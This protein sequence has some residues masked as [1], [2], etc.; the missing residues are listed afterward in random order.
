[1]LL[2][3]LLLAALMAPM[4]PAAD[5]KASSAEA[6]ALAYLAR[7]VP[8]W[9]RENHCF[10]CHNNGDAARALYAGQRAG[11]TIPPSAL[12]DTTAWLTHPHRWD[13]NGGRGPFSDKRLARVQF[14]TALAA[15]LEAGSAADP[16]A[17]V[18][19]AA[20]LVPDQAPDGSWPIEGDESGGPGSPATYGR[21]LATHLAR[22]YLRAADPILFREPIARA[23]RWL[24]EREIRTVTDASVALLALDSD[25]SKKPFT[26]QDS[27]LALL[28]KDQSEDG[29]WGPFA[30]SPPEVFDTALAVL[31]LSR[32]KL[33][34]DDRPLIARGRAFL[35]ERQRP[36]GSWIETTRPPGAESYA[37]RISTTGW[38]ALA[39]LATTDL[40]ITRGADPKR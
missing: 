12:A 14:T 17:L 39:L 7:E 2:E 26:A 20:L 19:A 23:G 5:P 25:P 6:L 28:R 32:I 4:L 3:P 8:R 34:P 31:G 29:G 35:I 21:P 10:S 16:G 33:D 1:M 22:E 24:A 9:S 30:A 40:S 18:E 15:A 11:H 38:A 27:C 37:Q 36:D 13:H